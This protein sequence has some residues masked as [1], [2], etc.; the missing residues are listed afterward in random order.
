[1]RYLF[2]LIAA[3]LVVGAVQAQVHFKVNVNIGSQ[4]AWGPTGY[5]HV[6]YYY[7]PDIESYYSVSEQRYYYQEN[8]RWIGR[9][10][11]P[12]RYHDYDVYNSYKVV[13]N[14]P[15]PYRH[16][17]KYRD[18]Y[19]SFKGRHDQQ[20]IRDSRDERY[21]VNKN[22]PEHGNWMKQQKHNNGN[23]RGHGKGKGQDRDH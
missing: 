17:E 23:G 15:S 12:P 21:F 5:D 7:L 4:P 20:P 1:M 9:S 19:A 3:M 18:Q 22:H 16:H 11:L 6:E 13:V 14:D 8:G 2:L 10:H